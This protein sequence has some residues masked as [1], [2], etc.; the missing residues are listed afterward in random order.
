MD[1]TPNKHFPKLFRKTF[2]GAIISGEPVFA[3]V[4]MKGSYA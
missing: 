1:A 3:G 2:V 4:L